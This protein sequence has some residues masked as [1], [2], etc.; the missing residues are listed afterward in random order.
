MTSFRDFCLK[1]KRYKKFI[2]QLN[3]GAYNI[4]LPSMYKQVDS[5]HATRIVRRLST[6]KIMIN[7]QKY[8]VAALLQNQQYRSDL[9]DLRNNSYKVHAV[10]NWH[11]EEIY[12][13]LTDK[14]PSSYKAL[15]N[16][17]AREACMSSLLS[18]AYT[19]SAQLDTFMAYV[20][21]VINDIDKASWAIKGI[22]DTLN[23]NSGRVPEL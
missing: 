15:G 11:V 1:N 18:Q 14:Y 4:D 17:Q 5:I 10:L 20:D 23:I 22:T 19:L 7:F 8:V 16:N 12:S 2:H 13:Y 3:E 6:K 9:V 21:I